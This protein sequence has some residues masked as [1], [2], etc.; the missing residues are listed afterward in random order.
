MGG[1]SGGFRKK[2][3]VIGAG[4]GKRFCSG[5][6]K[7]TLI[8]NTN[9]KTMK[10]INLF[11]RKIACITCLFLSIC[12]NAQT[13]PPEGMQGDGTNENPWEITLPEHLATLA[14]YV[15]AGYGE[16]TIGM[17]YKLVND[18]DLSKYTNWKP[19][20]VRSTSS[21]YT[22][23]HGN[24]NGNNKIVKNLTIRRSKESYIGLFGYK[25]DVGCIENLGVEDCDI[26]GGEYSVGGLVGDSSAPINNCYV[27]GMITGQGYHI[28]GL[29][30]MNSG[31]I[32][33]CHT[34]CS[35][36]NAGSIGGLV[37][38]NYGAITNCYATGSINA[39]KGDSGGLIGLNYG[40][41]SYCHA[42]C[43]VNGNYEA[44]G[45]IGSNNGNIF[46]C[47]ATG[48]VTGYSQGHGWIGGL[49]G[50]NYYADISNCYSTGNVNGPDRVGGLV[51]DNWIAPISNCFA[52]GSVTATG[53]L[54]DIGGLVGI[55]SASPILDCHATGN[56]VGYGNGVGGLVGFN[57]GNCTI[58]NCYATGDVSLTGR[59][60]N[61]VGGLVGDNCKSTISN[62]YAT[63]NVSGKE[64]NAGGLVGRNFG[65]SIISY[66]YATGSVSGSYN[67]GGLLGLNYW[68][69]GFISN[70]IAAN[71]SVIAT[72]NTT[73]VD[74]IVGNINYGVCSNN[75]A[76]NTM[77]VLSNGLPAKITDGSPKAG[78]G[79]PLDTL[80]NFAF[81]NL[82]NN[83]YNNAWDIDTE[84]N[85]N[86]IWKICDNLSLP[87]FQRQESDC[88]SY[89]TIIATA[90]YNGIINPYGE[91]SAVESTDRNFAFL[92]DA[93]YEVESLLIDGVN[94]PEFK[95]SGNYT[96]KD[97]TE[98]HTIHVTFTP[99]VNIN[100]N[101]KTYNF[102]VYPNPTRGEL[103]IESKELRIKGVEIFDIVGKKVFSN[104]HF[105]T[106]SNHLINIS[107]LQ[108]G[109]YFLQILTVNDVITKKIVKQ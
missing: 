28:G 68:E 81:Y 39:N 36:S 106:L 90:G 9:N 57:N 5:Q 60:R 10:K 59:L 44:G 101:E 27:T 33:N 86:K 99:K 51:G 77:I 16:S 95:A 24:F 56:V 47:Y 79:K 19:I 102:V 73:Y 41:I 21:Y 40:K 108:A 58:R 91:I 8:V 89:F 67:V 98:N 69:E 50:E 12:V 105:T 38:H 80:Q 46:E 66:C 37:G 11:L 29:V 76:L 22:S 107:H 48:N 23:F 55:N 30:G 104:H 49:V 88:G 13:W 45:L 61:H 87:L 94:K 96:F 1:K 3:R 6:Q 14:S 97:I 85:T 92:A 2:M 4:A 32:T 84:A 62:C 103:R 54:G 42:T 17:Y 78:I 7:T 109:F 93:G 65:N 25:S 34:T 43:T 72:T 52:T 53:Y 71:A 83:W 35:V 26:V 63:G 100:D 70:S 18:I 15:N 20:G 75:Y 31:V 64:E 82:A 74:R